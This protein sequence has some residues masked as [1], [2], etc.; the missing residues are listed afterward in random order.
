MSWKAALDLNCSDSRAAA[1]A[2]SY[3]GAV[4]TAEQGAQLCRNSPS[5]K[6]HWLQFCWPLSPLRYNCMSTAWNSSRFC[7]CKSQVNPRKRGL[8]CGNGERVRPALLSI[9]TLW[10]RT[11]TAKT[12]LRKK[13]KTKKGKGFCKTVTR[14]SSGFPTVLLSSPS[15]HPLT[16]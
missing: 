16:L 2:S 8:S 15:D 12:I 9:G 6:I 1:S 14:N 10:N 4:W 5:P 7:K 3:S 13:K 11:S